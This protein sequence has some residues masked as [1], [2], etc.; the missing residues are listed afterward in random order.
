MHANLPSGIPSPVVNL[1]V[2]R[3]QPIIATWATPLNSPVNITHFLVEWHRIDPNG[4]VN[5]HAEHCAANVT[6][7]AASN[8]F[9]FPHTNAN[10]HLHITVRS[11]SGTDVDHTS[12]PVYYSMPPSEHQQALN[13]AHA[14]LIGG[15]LSAMLVAASIGF[16]VW[17]R[18]RIAAKRRPHQ[19][20]RSV[21]D[22][23]GGPA[24]TRLWLSGLNG[25][26]SAITA[27]AAN[28]TSTDN[29]HEMQTLINGRSRDTPNGEYYALPS[30]PNGADVGNSEHVPEAD[31]QPL[32]VPLCTSTPAKTPATNDGGA[33]LQR[34]GLTEDCD[35][36]GDD[37]YAAASAI[38]N[39]ADIAKSV[40]PNNN[41]VIG[42]VH[43]SSRR[44]LFDES[45][46]PD[47]DVVD[48][49]RLDRRRQQ[50]QQ[51]LGGLCLPMSIASGKMTIPFGV[52]NGGQQRP[53]VGPNG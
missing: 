35:N 30:R 4:H 39:T 32:S 3:G 12:I 16:I 15:T 5:G 29:G 24:A 45:V 50:R 18:G 34:P 47:M 43:D 48:R 25:E 21:G 10:D 14:I 38:G 11:A 8:R 53:L 17:H 31:C 27:V 1:T 40:S 37:D 23:D 51:Q 36:D 49:D 9:T 44:P 19:P 42:G 46:T 41:V 20:H 52:S 2:A 33:L 6:A 7:V 28:T 22:G 26:A 13:R